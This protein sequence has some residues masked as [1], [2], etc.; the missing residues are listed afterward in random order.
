MM[1]W[2]CD[3]RPRVESMNDVVMSLCVCPGT[4]L[5]YCTLPYLLRG[6]GNHLDWP[7]QT[8]MMF[9]FDFDRVR[10]CRDGAHPAL[11]MS[12]AFF[13]DSR[14]SKEEEDLYEDKDVCS[15]KWRRRSTP[16]MR[17]TQQSWMPLC[18]QRHRYS[19]SPHIL[20]A[21]ARRIRAAGFPLFCGPSH[22]VPRVA[23]HASSQHRRGIALSLLLRDCY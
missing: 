1:S 23:W 8:T 21:T 13:E 19:Q 6:K 16:F 11:L 4:Y 10:I 17:A 12:T 2:S 22:D 15:M 9:R 7:W 18:S 20:Q 5:T 14:L 3:W